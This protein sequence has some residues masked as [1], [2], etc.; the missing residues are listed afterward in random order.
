MVCCPHLDFCQALQPKSELMAVL[1]NGSAFLLFPPF[2][3][4]SSGCQIQRSKPWCYFLFI[5]VYILHLKVIRRYCS[6]FLQ[7]I[8]PTTCLCPFLL[9]PP[10][11]S[12]NPTPLSLTNTRTSWLVSSLRFGPFHEIILCTAA[13][14]IL[15]NIRPHHS[16]DE[17]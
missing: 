16:F 11:L 1:P 9:L 3:K 10:W 17:K 14:V 15:K 7:N 8:S 13:K 2:C 4:S 12:Q 6:L 5:S